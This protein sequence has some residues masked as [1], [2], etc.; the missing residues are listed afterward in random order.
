MG[1]DHFGPLA[2]EKYSADPA[3]VVDP[4]RV[5]PPCLGM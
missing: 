3:S 4:E 5:G 1:L 2:L